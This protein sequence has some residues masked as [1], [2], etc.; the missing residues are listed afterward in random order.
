MS[1]FSRKAA[2]ASV[3]FATVG[4]TLF[5]GAA[6]AADDVTNAGGPGGRGGDPKVECFVP[7]GVSL[8]AIVGQGGDVS[9]CNAAGGAGGAGGAATADY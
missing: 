8:G 2:I 7:I 6:L 5:G 1:T 9:Q 4:S 3:A